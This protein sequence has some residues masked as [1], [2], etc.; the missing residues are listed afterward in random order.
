MH[1]FAFVLSGTGSLVSKSHLIVHCLLVETD[2][3]LVLVET[4]FGTQDLTR[5]SKK[6]WAFLSLSGTRRDLQNT[7]VHQIAGL[8]YNVR[9]VRHIVLT[10]LH[11][12]HAGGLPDFAWAKVHVHALEYEAAMQPQ[13]FLERYYAAEHWAHQPRWVL[14]T[15]QGE[16]WFEF[17][18]IRVLE[19]VRP[20][21][22]LVPMPGHTRGHCGVAVK[23]TEGW[24]LHCGDGYIFRGDV[25][26]EYGRGSRPRWMEPLARRLF[27]HVPRLQALVRHHGHKVQ[28]CCAHDALEL[29]EFQGSEL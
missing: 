18:C 25:K 4:G 13:T 27:P 9:D 11:L 3:G 12:D 6:V 5:P 29:S 23:T 21:I 22:L 17:D 2:D 20:E 19:G 16:R 1:P 14:H 10:H 26:P 7:A 28:L 24:L 8:G 15:W